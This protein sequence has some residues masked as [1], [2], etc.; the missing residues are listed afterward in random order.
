MTGPF[1]RI[2]WWLPLQEEPGEWTG[3]WKRVRDARAA[4]ATGLAAIADGAACGLVLL[5]LYGPNAPVERAA[6]DVAELQ[7]WEVDRDAMPASAGDPDVL[8]PRGREDVE[9][10]T[11]VRCRDALTVASDADLLHR[12]TVIA[13]LDIVQQAFH[14][15]GP[16][17]EAAAAS[18]ADIEPLSRGRAT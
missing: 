5:T 11:L 14:G 12:A 4:R 18:G 2:D 3:R 8:P 7:V 16:A 13:I 17:V 6:P 15:L 10:N 1:Y 9:G